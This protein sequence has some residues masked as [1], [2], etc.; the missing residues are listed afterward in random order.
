VAS[1]LALV[2]EQHFIDFGANTRESE[3]D[4][5]VIEESSHIESGNL[6]LGIRDSR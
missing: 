3:E 5:I 6:E 2:L 4:D 1:P